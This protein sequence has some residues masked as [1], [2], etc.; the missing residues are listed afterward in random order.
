MP[1]DSSPLTSSPAVKRAHLVYKNAQETMEDA[2]GK[3]N[4]ANI[5]Q[6]EALARYKRYLKGHDGGATRADADTLQRDHI[7]ALRYWRKC[8]AL[9]LETREL[10]MTTH[11][12]WLEAK[13]AMRLQEP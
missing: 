8:V 10:L 11:E 13:A 2:E 9:E 1:L 5:E 6:K 4:K 12:R 3:T 7:D